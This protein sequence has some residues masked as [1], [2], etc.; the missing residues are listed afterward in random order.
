MKIF[1]VSLSWYT[2]SVETRKGITAYNSQYTWFY[3]TSD[4]KQRQ[5]GRSEICISKQNLLK[6]K[7]EQ[8]LLK[9]H[10]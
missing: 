9:A 5:S 2:L 7:L 4:I 1:L 6:T 8:S 3:C 10:S